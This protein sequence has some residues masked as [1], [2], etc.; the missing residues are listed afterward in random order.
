VAKVDIYMPIIIGD[1]L[2]DTTDLLA[3]EHGAYLMILM[4]MWTA[5]GRLPVARLGPISRVPFERWPDVWNTISRF[6][7]VADGVATQGR[8]LRELSHAQQRREKARE[9]GQNGG[10]P[11]TQKKPAGKPDGN[12]PVSS[13]EPAGKP[14]RNPGANPNESSSSS[15]SDPRSDPQI[16]NASTSAPAEQK[17]LR[18]EPATGSPPAALLVFPTAGSPS[19][20]DLTERWV[21]ETQAAFPNVDVLAEARKALTKINLKAVPKKTAGGMSKFLLGWIGRTNDSA[22]SSTGPP[23]RDVSVGHY[24]APGPEKQYPK[25]PQTI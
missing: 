6:F 22:R 1:Y 14:E 16:L 18:L 5:G 9:N 21:T 19:S 20:W 17:A 2:K 25:G 13:G 23:A 4:S 10:R 8:L 7:D 15:S 12:R 3:E 24:P 11:K